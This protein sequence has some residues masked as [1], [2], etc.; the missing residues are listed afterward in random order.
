MVSFFNFF[1]SMNYVY[2]PKIGFLHFIDM[3]GGKY[4][5]HVVFLHCT[6]DTLPVV[7]WTAA[8]EAASTGQD[9][10]RW[11]WPESLYNYSIVPLL[12]CSRCDPV[13]DN[14]TWPRITLQK[15]H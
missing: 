15:A 9:Q 6:G 2:L 8:R 1:M 13:G 5:M 3:P 14:V 7:W 12:Q 10:D 11:V 4:S